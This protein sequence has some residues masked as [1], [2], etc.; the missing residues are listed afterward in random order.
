[1]LFNDAAGNFLAIFDAAFG[2]KS[3]LILFLIFY[4]FF[5][6]IIFRQIQLMAKKLPTPL[7]PALKFIGILHIGVSLTTFFLVSG[8]F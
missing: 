4:V 7:T 2:V 6:L 1:M 5:A 3:F 8:T